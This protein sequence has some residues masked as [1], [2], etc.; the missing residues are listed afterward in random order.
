MFT[1]ELDRLFM[2]TFKIGKAIVKEIN[3]C[4][5]SKSKRR[6]NYGK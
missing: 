4:N 5:K 6:R 3:K 1:K 2:T